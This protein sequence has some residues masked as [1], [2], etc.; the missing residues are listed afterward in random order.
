MDVYYGDTSVYF[1]RADG[2]FHPFDNNLTV[3]PNSKAESLKRFNPI[4]L[5][6]NDH[7]LVLPGI[8]ALDVVVSAA[9]RPESLLNLPEE[10]RHPI[11]KIPGPC[12]LKGLASGRRSAIYTCRDGHQHFKLKGCGDGPNGFPTRA[13]LPDRCAMAPKEGT[14]EEIRGCMFQHTCLRELFMVNEINTSL[15]KSVEKYSPAMQSIGWYEY[16]TKSSDPFPSVHPCCAV[17]RLYGERRLCDHLLLGLETILGEDSMEGSIPAAAAIGEGPTWLTLFGCPCPDGIPSAVTGS[18]EPQWKY[19]VTL[20]K[21]LGREAKQ[22]L[23]A[24]RAADISWGTYEDA[25]GYHCNAHPNNLVVLEPGLPRLLGPVDYDMAFHCKD[26]TLDFG[27]PLSEFIALEDVAML[28]GLAANEEICDPK[29]KVAEI[30]EDSKRNK[31]RWALRDTLINS[32][33]N[34]TDG[35]YEAPTEEEDQ[36]HRKWIQN[37]LEKTKDVIA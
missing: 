6:E 7:N 22:I 8:P 28:Q 13:V 9:P 10:L 4:K 12:D 1:Q 36:W 33:I 14:N 2:T 18:L 19:L 32:F 21:R 25:L 24:T 31:F 37:A 34:T 26:W 11:V 27:K 23:Q 20:Y 5:P 29:L 30:T 15:E 17:F 16:A 35:K 3:D